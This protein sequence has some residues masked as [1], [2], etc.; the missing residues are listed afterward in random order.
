[1]VTAVLAIALL[2]LIILGFACVIVRIIEAVTNTSH[3]VISVIILS[4]C[5][6]LLIVSFI[7]KFS[8]SETLDKETLDAVKERHARMLERC[9]TEVGECE[10]KWLDY[11]ADS[12]RAE[13]KVQRLKYE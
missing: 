1:M 8:F 6:V 13:Y 9:P 5:A 7:C 11:R 10:I 3:E 12:L 4:L 2:C